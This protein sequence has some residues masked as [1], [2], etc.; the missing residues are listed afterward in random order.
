MRCCR[1]AS[2]VRWLPPES[3]FKRRLTSH[4]QLLPAKTRLLSWCRKKRSSSRSCRMTLNSSELSALKSRPA[5]RPECGS[6]PSDLASL[7]L[8]TTSSES[9]SPAPGRTLRALCRRR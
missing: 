4:I 8:A 6:L 5:L 7:S 3:S 1:T 9:E 2:C